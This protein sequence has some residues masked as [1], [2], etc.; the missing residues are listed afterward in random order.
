MDLEAK[1]QPCIQNWL[2]H[3]YLGFLLENKMFK[4]H[5]FLNNSP[6]YQLL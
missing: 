1:R 4:L 6:S 5:M 2:I 3:V